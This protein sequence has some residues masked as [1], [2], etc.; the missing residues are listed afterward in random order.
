MVGIVIPSVQVR[1][2]RSKEVT[3]LIR[4]QTSHES[5][6]RDQTRVNQTLRSRFLISM[7]YQEPFSEPTACGVPQ[8]LRLYIHSQESALRS[9]GLQKETKEQSWK[10]SLCFLK[11][12]EGGS[13]SSHDDH[14]QRIQTRP[15]GG[16]LCTFVTL[17]SEGAFVGAEDRGALLPVHP[18]TPCGKL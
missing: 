15:L 8:R 14:S 12:P 5:R 9:K 16:L 11:E 6:T 1:K 17:F 7:L 13:L 10:W 4:D 18:P 2:L 3:W